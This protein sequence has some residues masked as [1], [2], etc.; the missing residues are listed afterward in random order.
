MD[1]SWVL[2][3]KMND[4]GDLSVMMIIAVLGANSQASSNPFVSAH[5]RFLSTTG[6][7]SKKESFLVVKFYGGCSER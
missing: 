1:G 4:D 2:L 3:N 6:W 5:K 7:K